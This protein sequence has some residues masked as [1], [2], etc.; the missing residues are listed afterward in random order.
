MSSVATRPQ[1]LAAPPAAPPFPQQYAEWLINVGLAEQ[2]LPYFTGRGQWSRDY[3]CNAAIA[4]ACLEHS[5]PE[6][7]RRRAPGTLDRYED[8]INGGRHVDDVARVLVHVT[9][10]TCGGIHTLTSLARTDKTLVLRIVF[11]FTDEQ[12]PVEGLHHPASNADLIALTCTQAIA[13][14]LSLV[15]AVYNGL[16]NFEAQI[17]KMLQLEQLPQH[18]AGI[19]FVRDNVRQVNNVTRSVAV[20]AAILKAYEYYAEHTNLIKRLK[21]FCRILPDGQYNSVAADAVAGT[22]HT[23]LAGL[24]FGKGSDREMAYCWTEHA[25]KHFM[26]GTTGRGWPKKPNGE[27]FNGKA[28]ASKKRRRATSTT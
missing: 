7:I 3:R 28:P 22:L 1:Q 5:M 8:S 27:Q 21:A 17:D 25:I 14:D 26:G 12:I 20:R 2:G 18:A 23:K 9:G 10:L 11:G 13:D 24:D 4:A 19:A 15:R 6:R 16:D